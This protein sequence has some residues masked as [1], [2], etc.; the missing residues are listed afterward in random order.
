MSRVR[1]RGVKSL[2]HL[3]GRVES[4]QEVVESRGSGRRVG[5]GGFQMSRI[6]SGRVGSGRVGSGRVKTSKTICGSGWVGSGHRPD[7]TRPVRFDLSRE[8]P[9]LLVI[10]NGR[11]RFPRPRGFHKHASHLYLHMNR[12]GVRLRRNWG[13]PVAIPSR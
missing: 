3:M 12:P 4:G 7:P 11:A 13:R 2:S 5:S 10:S 6:G 9:W 1:S 8:Q